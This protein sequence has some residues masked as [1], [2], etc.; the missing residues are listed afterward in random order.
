MLECSI[1]NIFICFVDVFI[2]RQVGGIP[3]RTH[4]ANNL[5]DFF[6]RGRLL[7]WASQEKPKEA[8]PIL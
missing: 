2:N 1:D 8:C 4:C 7:T 6:D 3:M 5:A